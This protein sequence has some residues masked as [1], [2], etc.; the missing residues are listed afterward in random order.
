M[1]DG[2]VTL[3][4]WAGRGLMEVARVMYALAGKFPQAGDYEDSRFWMVEGNGA[5]AIADV[6]DLDMSA[7][8]GRF[9]LLSV[10]GKGTIGQS[11]AIWYYVA[12][13]CG[14]LGAN[15]WETAQIISVAETLKETMDTFRKA[16][17]YGEDPKPE[18][19]DKWFSEGSNDLTGRANMEGRA[20]RQLHWFMGRLENLI[21]GEN[22]FAV[23]GKLSLADV[24]IYNAFAEHLDD[25][26]A[27]EAVKPYGKGPYTDLKRTS[28][29]LAKHPKLKAICD[30][31]AGNANFQKWRKERGVQNF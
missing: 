14:F 15:A 22:G 25:D 8:L 28:E 19:V 2:K 10:E 12:S 29:E 23:G 31:I 20:N 24:L 27:S 18:A 9:P 1:S 6:G 17:P 13:E 30:N 7:N 4:Y 16:V 21:P 11:L 5:K 3:H 26:Q